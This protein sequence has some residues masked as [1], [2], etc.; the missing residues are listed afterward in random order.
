MHGRVRTKIRPRRIAAVGN[1]PDLR[2]ANRPSASQSVRSV[3]EWG[4]MTLESNWTSP[5]RSEA[6]ALT[7]SRYFYKLLG[8]ITCPVVGV[9]QLPVSR[10]RRRSP[11]VEA[12]N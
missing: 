8:Q 7:A 10:L 6:I 5:L 1:G 3:A 4:Y 12:R 11:P 2:T 9:S